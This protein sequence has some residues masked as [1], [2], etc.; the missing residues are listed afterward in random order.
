MGG[1][2]SEAPRALRERCRR[3]VSADGASRAWA[4]PSS[5]PLLVRPAQDARSGPCRA[6]PAAAADATTGA[7]SPPA[8]ASDHAAA[9]A[10]GR[11]ASDHASCDAA[12]PSAAAAASSALEADREAGREEEEEEEDHRRG[13]LA[14][15]SS[16][17][18]MACLT[19]SILHSGHVWFCTTQGSMQIRWK[20]WLEMERGGSECRGRAVQQRAAPEMQGPTAGRLTCTA[21]P[22]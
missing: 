17:V 3:P 19:T 8:A 13:G 4:S 15:C 6:R 21:A 1:H 7:R 2:A 20:R 12:P 10:P 9:C 16:P 11:A 22:A 18:R 14:T 5:R